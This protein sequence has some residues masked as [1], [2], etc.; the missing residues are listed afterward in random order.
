MISA[1]SP[2]QNHLIIASGPHLR[3]HRTTTYIMGNVLIALLPI[4]V[5]TAYIF[6][7][8]VFLSTAVAAITAI[9]S[10]FLIQKA[11]KREQTIQNLSCLVTA[12]IL[13]LNLP[14]DFPL[15]QLIIGT[16]FAIIVVKA[17]FGGLGQNFANP[18]VT[19]RIVLVSAFASS[20]AKNTEPLA[21]A[22]NFSNSA[23]D[24]IAGST[25]DSSSGATV[26]VLLKSGTHPDELRTLRDL[27]FGIQKTTAIG[28]TCAIAILLGGLYLLFKKIIKWHIPVSYIGTVAI[29]SFLFGGFDMQF[30]LYHL[31]SG[32]LLFGAFFMAT[33][34]ATSPLTDKGKIVFGIGLGILTSIIRFWSNLPEGVS[35]SILTMNILTPHIDRFTK[36]KPFG[37]E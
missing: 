21:R 36:E 24:S 15:W 11:M 13:V 23:L 2:E 34:Y 29:L 28:E 30:M 3:D 18:A 16:I 10:E 9:L 37:T 27:F 17:A 6:G 25:I 1:K 7:C 35:F 14:I 12:V 20:F 26:L 22:L 32:G 19:T 4:V 5:A 31:F 8:R 33:D